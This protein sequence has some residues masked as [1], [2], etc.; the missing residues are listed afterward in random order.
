MSV[1]GCQG[2]GAF[3]ELVKTP[4]KNLHSKPPDLSFDHAT[5]ADPVGVT[6]HAIR[7]A[8]DV[9]GKNCLVFGAGTMG[10]LLAQ[11][12]QR[13][14]AAS[15]VIA[16]I[17]EAHLDIAAGLGNF[18]IGNLKKEKIGKVLGT[19][20]I[21]CTF[22]TAGGDSP[23]L[24]QS[25]ELTSK[26]GTVVLISQRPKGAFIHYPSVLFKELKLQGVFS[27]TI[28]DFT[29]AIELLGAGKIQVAPLIT[30]IFS[31][32]DIQAAYN[33]FQKPDSIKVMVNPT[34]D[35]MSTS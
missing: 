5:F 2:P 11:N 23:T 35:V 25:I 21:N 16:D 10:L 22:D 27:Q 19:L 4:V 7:L 24:G 14:D 31:L 29:D 8:G 15:V 13:M 30:K 34:Q 18:T 6:I 1:I 17:N 28:A 32:A 3:A 9:Q 20:K 12:L 26:G 33:L